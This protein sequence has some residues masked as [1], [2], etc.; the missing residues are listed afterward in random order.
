MSLIED[1]FGTALHAPVKR[2]ANR[3]GHLR[4]QASR[5]SGGASE[6]MVKVTS[7]GKGGKHVQAQ[8]DYISRKGDVE[9][10]NDRGETF[11]GK[12]AVR[13]LFK[14]WAEE[15]GDTKR[16]ANQRDTMHLV[17][18]M[19]EGTEPEA[20][21]AA[22]RQFTRKTF[23][24]NHEYVFAL[25]T[26]E[27]HPHCHVTVKCL[28]F[29][30]KR[31]NPRKADLQAWREGF[32]EAMWSQGYEAEAT[33]RRSRGVV[34]KAENSVVRHIERGDKTHAP[35]TSRVRA[36]R[37][38]EAAEALIAEAR[39]ESVPAPPWE[40]HIEARQRAVR[41][42]WLA[43]AR[44]LEQPKSP[45]LYQ[46]EPRHELPDYGRL[47]A[48]R[49]Q[50]AAA[51]YQSGLEKSGFQQQAGT[52]AGLRN[53]SSL[54]LVRDQR[55][56]EVLLQPHARDRVGHAERLGADHDVRRARA[57]AHGDAGAEQ[58]VSRA[59]AASVDDKALAARIRGFVASMPRIETQRDETRRSLLERFGQRR[60]VG[61]A[62]G[63]EPV[64]APSAPPMPTP[65]PTRDQD[66]E[67]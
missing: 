12:D 54:P 63:I 9:L 52:L 10:E 64:V 17:L 43:A 20:V 7:F 48:G 16:H 38:K 61:Q 18:S 13:G 55:G 59:E 53:V 11:S 36:A 26:D 14:E 32:A 40:A 24:H 39:G 46:Q 31:L 67:R 21:Q 6:V 47:D 56:T 2:K 15:F 45:I 1:E 60:E 34:R 66:M 51:L 30:G 49:L 44:A 23:G 57:G 8:L 37:V 25:H 3:T 5:V 58:E 65:T 27:R 22:A 28:G 29:D 41:G 19:P 62:N 50:R 33:P 4:S 42:A 35:R